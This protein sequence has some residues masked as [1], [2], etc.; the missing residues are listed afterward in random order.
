MDL[1]PDLVFSAVQ[2][3]DLLLAEATMMKRGIDEDEVFG[4]KSKKCDLACRGQGPGC[5]SSMRGF[6]GCLVRWRRYG[7]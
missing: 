3:L 6:R 4:L 2:G 5:G 1:A 7:Y